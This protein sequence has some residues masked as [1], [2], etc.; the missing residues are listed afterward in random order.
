M[1]QQ[2]HAPELCKQRFA[3]LPGLLMSGVNPQDWTDFSYEQ[4]LRHLSEASFTKNL[5]LKFGLPASR[6]FVTFGHKSY[7]A[8]LTR[9]RNT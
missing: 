6:I 9:L 3:Y 4:I 8:I 2:G 7:F 1:G 5:R